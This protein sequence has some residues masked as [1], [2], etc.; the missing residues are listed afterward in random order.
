MCPQHEYFSTEFFWMQPRC[1]CAARGHIFR[2]CIIN[3]NTNRATGRGC[4]TMDQE[5]AV[6]VDYMFKEV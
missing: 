6:G 3:R 4:D 2:E 1:F 5:R